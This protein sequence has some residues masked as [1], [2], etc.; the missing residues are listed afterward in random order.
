M[1]RLLVIS[2]ADN[3]ATALET[4]SPGDVLPIQGRTIAIA[5]TIPRGHK[6]ALIDLPAGTA[7]IKYGSPIGRTSAAIA[8]GM[9]VHTHSLASTR[10]RGDLAAAP[11]GGARLAEP[12]DWAVEPLP[13]SE[14]R[15]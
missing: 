5:E 9:H 13:A 14:K 7:V 3:V 1:N 15:G 4:L 6:V 2:P 11:T 8:A 12:P 10:G